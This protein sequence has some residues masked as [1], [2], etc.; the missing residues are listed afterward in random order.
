MY[1]KLTAFTGAPRSSSTGGGESDDDGSGDARPGQEKNRSSIKVFGK[2]NPSFQQFDS[3]F[4]PPELVH[5]WQGSTDKVLVPSDIRTWFPSDDGLAFHIPTNDNRSS[6]SQQYYTSISYRQLHE[7][8]E[9]CPLWEKG[10]HLM[11]DN[12]DDN[13]VFVVAVLLPL[14]WMAETAIVELC[15]M[16]GGSKPLSYATAVAPLD[17]RMNNESIA[18]ALGQ[19]D[20][21]GIVTTDDLLKSKVYSGNDFFDIGRLTDI[22]TVYRDN[23]KPGFII[24]NS[25]FGKG[26]ANEEIASPGHSRVKD[27]KGQY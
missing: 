25:V 16:A 4:Y 3:K 21:R 15:V 6:S 14:E 27:T 8:I 22:R 12:D 5:T 19:L 1:S 24:W 9:M 26:N 11:K 10:N 23:S 20:C 17:P 7:N 18:Q 13:E 2:P